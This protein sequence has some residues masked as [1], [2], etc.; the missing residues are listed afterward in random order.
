MKDVYS[1]L[2]STDDNIIFHNK[3]K[4]NTISLN[5]IYNILTEVV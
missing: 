1:Y 5:N 2:G 3:L 4:D